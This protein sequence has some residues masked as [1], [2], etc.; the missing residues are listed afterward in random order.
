MA[1]VT[2]RVDR[3][4]RWTQAYR[5]LVKGGGLDE[6]VHTACVQAFAGED[7]EQFP[8]VT[9]E[10]VEWLLAQVSGDREY[11]VEAKYGTGW[12]TWEGGT[13]YIIRRAA[14]EAVEAAA[15][16]MRHLPDGDVWNVPV[17]LASAPVQVWTPEEEQ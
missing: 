13:T 6:T 9:V 10:D 7:G 1:D 17:R 14:E 12:G 3:L 15:R 16:S 8:F 5:H 11:R 2:G 4:T